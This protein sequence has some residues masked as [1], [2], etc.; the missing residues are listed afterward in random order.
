MVILSLWLEWVIFWAVLAKD[1]VVLELRD[2][3]HWGEILTA[4]WVVHLNKALRNIDRSNISGLH[5]IVTDL[6]EARCHWKWV[7]VMIRWL[8]T[9]RVIK[10]WI[11]IFLVDWCHWWSHLSYLRGN[12]YWTLKDVF[13]ETKWQ[14]PCYVSWILSYPHAN[15]ISKWQCCMLPL[16]C[17]VLN[18]CCYLLFFLHINRLTISDQVYKHG[19]VFEMGVSV[20][21]VYENMMQHEL[22]SFKFNKA[23]CAFVVLDLGFS[24]HSH[25]LLRRQWQIQRLVER[26][27][28]HWTL[29]S[30]S[31]LA[32]KLGLQLSVH[33][34]CV[35]DNQL[36]YQKLLQLHSAY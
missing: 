22:V 14:F 33:L 9:D 8:L 18:Y 26:E 12:L 3:W 31:T 4:P 23:Q 15:A 17:G 5:Y 32:L 21:K 25:G 36:F 30:L 28:F 1:L 2:A 27:L 6:G 10:K 20:I 13:T 29:T 34:P 7:S 19:F 35:F 16:I 11:N 24:Y